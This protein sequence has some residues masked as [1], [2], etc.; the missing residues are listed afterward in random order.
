[1][2]DDQIR[3]LIAF[4]LIIFILVLWTMFSKPKNRI[5]AP[6]VT[7]AKDTLV[8]KK[9]TELKIVSRDT[10]IVDRPEYRMVLASSGG[11]VKSLFLK[12]YQAELVPDGQY[13]FITHFADQDS[14]RDFDYY[15][16]GDSVV[17]FSVIAGDTVKKSYCFNDVAGFDLVV[18]AGPSTPVLSFK[19]GL[20]LTEVKNRHEDLR[21]YG[22]FVKNKVV[23]NIT[24]KI[25]DNYQST[26]GIDWFS[27]RNK[28]FTLII[29]NSGAMDTVNFYRIPPTAE[30]Y[31]S[32]SEFGKRPVAAAFGCAFGAGNTSR[33]G[34]EIIG[35]RELKL[36]VRFL[37]LRQN[38]LA[39]YGCGYE[40]MAN[41][42]L[43]GFIA[44]IILLIFQF[45]F[46]LFRNYGVAIILFAIL[47]KAVFFPLSRKMIIS[48]YK[49]QMLQPELKKIQE[50]YKNDSAALN[51]EMMHL[52][53][54][55]KVNPF[56]GCLP[57]L[58]QFPVFM[59]LYQTLN[60]SIEFRQARFAFWLVDLS[61]KDPFY[62]LPIGMGI[63]M[64]IQSFMT[65]ID[66]RQRMM[67]VIMPLFMIFIFLNLPSGLQLYWFTFNILTLVENYIVK[68]GGFK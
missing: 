7:A 40:A 30:K 64:L 34:A 54:A 25:K 31:G 9:E 23:E 27:I 61:L 8:L 26:G 12:N 21:H 67:V 6:P 59:A 22:V 41:F 65:P 49:M 39:R 44:R 55:Y 51:Q 50:K 62:V 17:F 15:Q 36:A 24:R 46:T 1:M 29:N 47:L 3:T 33:Y 20:R 57:L 60:T 43:W 66:P 32:G 58:I 52:Y 53:K 19:A 35:P 42:G 28:Y 45:F 38:D 63:M 48:Q 10:V 18:H 2:R 16:R 14:V 56:S 13:L 5:P 11:S 68:R 4:A 37:P